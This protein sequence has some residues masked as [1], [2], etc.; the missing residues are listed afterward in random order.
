MLTPD[1]LLQGRYQIRYAVDEHP[2]ARIYR[3]LD[4]RDALPVLIAALPQ[5]AT[6]SLQAVE[7][8]TRQIAAIQV[9]GLLPVCDHFADDAAVYLVAADPGGQDLERVARD[10]RAAW[11]EPQVFAQME[12]LLQVLAEVHAAQPPLYLGELR[13]TDLWATPEGELALTPF[14]FARP[15]LPTSS[16]Y[17]AP[18][19]EHSPAQPTPAS[20]LYALAAVMYHLLTGWSPPTAEQRRAGVPLNPP[21]TLNAQI[22]PLTE[23]MLLRALDLQ[24]AN[25]YQQA[26]EL[27][28]ALEVVP[29]LTAR[30][31]E[32]EI[33]A[34]PPAP[35]A[36]TPP[37]EP[38][39]M[40]LPANSAAA[41]D[42]QPPAK[43]AATQRGNTCLLIIVVVLALVA[44]GICV[45]GV[46]LL[47][48][49]GQE[50][51]R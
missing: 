43:P 5:S 27:R 24:P 16:P 45:T 10:N 26:R 1:T 32:L 35:L 21:R 42:S 12:R 22:T 3:A 8:L 6:D 38:P 4:Q 11:S 37:V 44:L 20:D 36:A 29:V 33:A 51:L 28:A 46:W 13:S 9:A 31:P 19:L 17:R 18:E 14:L 34:A 49:P 30:A 25:R 50:L 23:Q 40:A 2:A 7:Q 48:G 39:L 15:R 47:T 41:E